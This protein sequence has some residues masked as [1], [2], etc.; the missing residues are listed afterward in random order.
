MSMKEII[1]YILA[2]LVGLLPCA[3][4][5]ESVADLQL[6]GFDEIYFLTTD[7]EGDGL[8]DIWVSPKE[9]TNGVAGNIWYVFRQTPSGY[10]RIKETP[11]VRPDA[12][13]IADINGEKVIK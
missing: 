5:S 10:E 4:F 6:E 11:I 2:L 1:N 8:K 9:W 3:L 13:H 12:F 7:L